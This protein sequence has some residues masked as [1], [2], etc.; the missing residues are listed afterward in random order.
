MVRVEIG[1]L[2]RRYLACQISA[3]KFA[4]CTRSRDFFKLIAANCQQSQ[5][6]RL[7]GFITCTTPRNRQ[8]CPHQSV[9][10]ITGDFR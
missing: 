4:K 10:K 9:A 1:A 5:S 6:V 8:V 3:I 7:G 2:N